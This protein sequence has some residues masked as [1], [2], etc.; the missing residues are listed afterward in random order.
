MYSTDNSQNFKEYLDDL[1][2][3][4][5]EENDKLN[6]EGTLTE[7]ECFDALLSM[8]NNKCPGSDGLSFEFYKMFW[9]DV[10]DMLLESLNE[11][12]KKGTLSDSQRH[13]LLTLL[14]KKGDKRILDNWRP[15]SLLNTDYKIAARAL[16]KRLQNVIPKLI[17]FD[18]MGYIKKR[19]AAE[20]IRLVQD[21]LDFCSYTNIPGIFM[22]LDF[23]KAFDNVEHEFLFETLKRFNFGTSFIQWIKTI[24]NNAD[25]KVINNGW[26]SKTF[27]ITKGVRQ[28]CP[29]SA[30]LFLLVVEVLAMKIRNNNKIIGIQVPTHEK[31]LKTEIKISQLADDT[32]IFVDSVQSGNEAMKEVQA[33]GLYAGPKLN[34]TKTQ[35]IDVNADFQ[36]CIRG[37][38]WAEEPV[39][40][41][42][43]FVS[44][45]NENLEHLNWFIKLEKIKKIINLWKMRN[46]TYYGKVTII[47]SLLVSQLVYVATVYT[48]P[49]KFVTELNKI[50]FTFYGILGEKNL[51]EMLYVIV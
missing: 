35:V 24:Y 40:Y 43:V 50:L 49:P 17:S 30:L 48:V 2:F 6:C 19:S 11:G 34:F 7:K 36:E 41:L 46:L 21:L 18:Q 32:T 15:I 45:K 39:K 25:G 23:K 22:F 38:Q 29:L 37:L 27:S 10:K 42:G 47:K 9:L 28:G 14:Y 51:K 12:Y 1:N 44:R 16:A 3:V 4:V 5:L 31:E 20:N 8:K 13:A 26:L 33:F